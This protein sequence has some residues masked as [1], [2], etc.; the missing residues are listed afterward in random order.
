MGLSLEPRCPD[1]N[2]LGC[3]SESQ[4]LNSHGAISWHTNFLQTKSFKGRIVTEWNISTAAQ[5]LQGARPV[6][7]FALPFTLGLLSFSTSGPHGCN[8]QQLVQVSQPAQQNSQQ[9]HRM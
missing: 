1:W 5:S 6:L 9:K 4:K 8:R 3:L 2:V 7:P